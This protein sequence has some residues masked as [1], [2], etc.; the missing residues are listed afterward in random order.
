LSDRG[1]PTARAVYFDLRVADD[2]TPF[3]LIMKIAPRPGGEVVYLAYSR[4]P[5]VVVKRLER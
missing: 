4:E 1:L 5:R 3:L 2:G